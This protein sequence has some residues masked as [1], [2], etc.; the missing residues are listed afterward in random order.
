VPESRTIQTPVQS[1]AG[2][3]GPWLKT[4]VLESLRAE[5]LALVSQQWLHFVEDYIKPSF[6]SRRG[7]GFHSLS[8]I[9]AKLQSHRSLSLATRI[10]SPFGI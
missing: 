7:Y 8:S 10:Q 9:V 2:D 4:P 1:W 5:T 6:T 3:F